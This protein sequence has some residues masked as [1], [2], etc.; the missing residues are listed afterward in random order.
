MN[1]VAPG[2]FGVWPAAGIAFLPCEFV[3]PPGLLRLLVISISVP[4]AQY[5]DCLLLT[6]HHMFCSSLVSF[7]SS[8]RVSKD[9]PYGLRLT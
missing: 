9:L 4:Y 7:G 8:S 3:F 6:M 2:S 1:R 5:F